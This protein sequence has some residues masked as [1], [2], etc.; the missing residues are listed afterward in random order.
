MIKLERIDL[1]IRDF[2]L[3]K[4]YSNGSSLLF[5]RVVTGI[6]LILSLLA[7][8]SDFVLLHGKNGILPYDLQNF[9][10]PDFALT[11]SEIVIF[12]ES[13][14]I[15]ENTVVVWYFILYIT[16]AGMLS[17]GLFTRVSAI[18]CLILYVAITSGPY[19]YG[20]DVFVTTSLFYLVLFP[21]G[22]IKSV[23]NLIFKKRDKNVNFTP[24]LRVLQINL[25]LVYF[26]AG[27]SKCISISWYNG[28]AIWKT[29]NFVGA[30]HLLKLNF[31]V[32]ARFPFLLSVISITV[33]V[34]EL[35]YF[36]LIWNNKIR[37]FFLF[38]VLAMHIGIALVLNLY[39]FASFMILL[40]LTCF[41][42]EDHLKLKINE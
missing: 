8:S 27:L 35:F 15:S 42:V 41:Y 13:F 16:F 38:G 28:D 3:N 29:I 10:S 2:L 11:F 33:V 20:I 34:L 18:I 6:F 17:I 22:K 21:V 36:I 24:Y 9:V 14:G 12:F 19:K 4:D 37:K 39:F 25:C 32:L 26:F 23:D 7:I 5:L 40:N 30:N 1:K 31:D